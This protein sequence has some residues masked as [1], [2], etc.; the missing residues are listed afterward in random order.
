[1]LAKPGVASC[2]L[3]R[4]G[5]GFGFALLYAAMLVKTNRIYRIF[6][7]ARMN[8]QPKWISPFSQVST[9]DFSSGTN[10]NAKVVITCLLT[11][12]QLLGSIIWLLAQQ[13]GTLHD[14]PDL[15][16]KVPF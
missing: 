16:E 2:T 15:R 11:G 6:H 3:R 1:M 14:F 13:P 8:I 9:L 5:V 7:Y 10:Q 4:L 12:V